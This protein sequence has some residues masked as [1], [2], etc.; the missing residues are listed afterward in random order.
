MWSNSVAPRA[1][2]DRIQE[3][4][5]HVTA[6]AIALLGNTRYRFNRGSSETRLESVQLKNIRPCREEGIASAREHDVE[7]LEVRR[8]IILRIF[9][10]TSD[11]ILRMFGHPRMIRRQ[12]IRHEIE[13]QI[14]APLRE[15]L[16]RN[17]Q[18]LRTSKMCVYD[19]ASH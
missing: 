13:N 18:T 3:Q 17:R 16:P 12:V 15:L 9:G 1:C 4:H 19:V 10:T 2:E 7:Q 11:E 5:G 6:N 14:H 8:W